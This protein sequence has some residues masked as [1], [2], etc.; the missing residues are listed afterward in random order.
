VKHLYFLVA[1]SL[2]VCFIQP[3]DHVQ[4]QAETKSLYLLTVSE[5][6]HTVT[7]LDL[8]D[9]SSMTLFSVP[10]A[11]QGVLPQ[12]FPPGE[13]D[14]L[15]RYLVDYSATVRH[16]ESL[17]E[18]WTRGRIETI[19]VSPDNRQVLAKVVYQTCFV[20][21]NAVCFG[22]TQLVLIDPVSQEQR[23]LLNL[24][25][26][27][28]QFLPSVYQ[29]PRVYIR[30]MQWTPDQQAIVTQIS[31]WQASEYAIVVVPT[32]GVPP[33]K[34]GEGLTW[35]TAPDGDQIVILSKYKHDTRGIANTLVM[36]NIDVRTGQFSQSSYVLD[37]YYI[38][39]SVGLAFHEPFV[40]F[41]RAFDTRLTEFRDTGEGLA[42]F[43]TRTGEASMVLPNQFFHKIQ[44]TPDAAHLVLETS[45][46]LLVK[47]QLQDG[48]MKLQSLVSAPV[49]A[50][51]LGSNGDLLVQFAGDE[52]YQLLDPQGNT[53]ET[54]SSLGQYQRQIMQ[55]SEANEIMAADW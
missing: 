35:T 41:Q 40:V 30:Q 44:S 49:A 4:A 53:I 8:V 51:K 43:D 28:D 10:T 6:A 22:T 24:G 26:H 27:D 50:W 31:V 3:A 14:A 36:V 2:L 7:S 45:D 1:V 17:S 39:D 33:F 5:D 55:A 20:P 29:N 23:I 42:A 25:A 52:T 54:L 34:I 15:N 46:N 32:D 47:A 9:G 12:L 38:S 19:S 21:Q 13:I 37:Y 16:V 11:A 18:L 48:S